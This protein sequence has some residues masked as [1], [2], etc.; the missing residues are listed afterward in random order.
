MHELMNA[1]ISLNE[2]ESHSDHRYL[3]DGNN[4]WL[5]N[6]SEDVEKKIVTV[7]DRNLEYIKKID[8]SNSNHV[9][10]KLEDV[11]WPIS[12][13]PPFILSILLKGDF[14]YQARLNFAAFFVGNGLTK[15]EIPLMVFKLYNQ[16]WNETRD[17]RQRLLKFE[18]LFEYL[19]VALKR[20]DF[21]CS[22]IRDTYYFYSMYADHM[23]YFDGD[24]RDL[25]V[26][27]GK[28]M[29]YKTGHVFH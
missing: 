27:G 16:Y 20:N 13:L 25:R 3:E 4:D 18:N 5:L 24:L 29:K 2:P 6:F 19:N 1:V 26:R 8:A 23:M 22:K 21:Q 12:K 7:Q 17:W 10:N 28:R 11:F 9:K 14:G 15:P